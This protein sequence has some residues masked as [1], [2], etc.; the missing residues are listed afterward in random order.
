MAFLVSVGTSASGPAGAGRGHRD[1]E[2]FR[3]PPQRPVLIHDTAG[4]P[5]PARRSQRCVSV[6][7][8]GLQVAGADVAIHTEPGG[9][10]SR[11]DHQHPCRPRSTGFASGRGGVR[12]RSRRSNEHSE[13]ELSAGARVGRGGSYR[14]DQR[15][16]ARADFH[17]HVVQ[18]GVAR[19]SPLL[20]GL[21]VRSSRPRRQLRHC[22]ISGT[23]ALMTS[24][25][26][27]IDVHPARAI[28]F[29]RIGWAPQCIP[30]E[31][32]RG[33]HRNLANL[34]QFVCR[35]LDRDGR[36]KPFT[37]THDVDESE[38]VLLAL[39]GKPSPS[40]WSPATRQGHANTEPVLSRGDAGHGG[41]CHVFGGPRCLGRHA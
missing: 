11:Q 6:S 20:R 25:F 16:R 21:R 30:E 4:Q 10:P 31:S 12:G 19:H 37:D 14:S 24:G 36:N 18:G 39:R 28:P 27:S 5:Q 40:V 8:E 26:L 23:R 41:S 7:R 2:P 13:G 22:M 34:R 17:V 9:P 29:R 15:G 3:G 35:E 32:V 1:L 38:T 33:H